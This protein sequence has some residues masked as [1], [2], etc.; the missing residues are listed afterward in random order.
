MSFTLRFVRLLFGVPAL[1]AL[2]LFWQPLTLVAML[3]ALALFVLLLVDMRELP[4]RK[5]VRVSRDLAP[6][7]GIGKQCEYSIQVKAGSTSLQAAEVIDTIPRYLDASDLQLQGDKWTSHLK[8]LKRGDYEVGPIYVRYVGKLGLAE[9]R[10][11]Y[12]VNQTVRIIPETPGIAELRLRKGLLRTAGNRLLRLS[13][14]GDEFE[15]LRQYQPDDDPRHIDWRSTARKGK[16]LTRSYQPESKQRVL[17]ALDLGRTMLGRS[18]DISK[19]DVVLNHCLLMAHT[20]L[21]EGDGVG[22]MAFADKVL[23]RMPVASGKRQI[24]Q[25]LDLAADLDAEPVETDYRLLLRELSVWERK[26]SLVI[27]FTDF[28][29]ES[30]TDDLRAALLSIGKRHRLLVVA[31]RDPELYELARSDA[32]NADEAFAVAAAAHLV[33]HRTVAV[34]ALEKMGVM[35]ANLEHKD[36]AIGLVERYL[37][38]RE[39]AAF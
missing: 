23:A 1:V 22:F 39:M 4:A 3:Y 2:S 8:G 37:R 19:S 29:D 18:G 9:R 31:V 15:S 12:A 17:I 36:L 13:G 25:L 10:F 24:Q 32:S 6:S 20:A 33:M 28:I 7:L 35:V 14:R 30:Q 11:V 27:L 38:M 5:S 26:R 16:L 34:R 21:A